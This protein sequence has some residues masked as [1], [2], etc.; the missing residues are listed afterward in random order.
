SASMVWGES[1]TPFLLLAAFLVTAS[2]YM[3]NRFSDFQEDSINNP[4]RI[5]FLRAGKKAIAMIYA[6]FFTVAAAILWFKGIAPFFTSLIFPLMVAAYSLRL[7]QKSKARGLKQLPF[8]KNAFTALGWSMLVF[9]A[10]SYY[11]LGWLAPPVISF[12]LLV[13]LWRFVNVA[14]ADFKDV[15][16]DSIAGVATLPVVLGVRKTR[17][18]LQTVN[19]AAVAVTTW[20]VWSAVLPPMAYGLAFIGVYVAYYVEESSRLVGDERVSEWSSLVLDSECVWW[21]VLVSVFA[22]LAS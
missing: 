7:K 21:A 8:V 5:T 18:V 10:A 11:G 20:L 2:S 22:R 13:L 14:A 12:F 4:A 9:L 6:V 16:G 1:P 17:I 3:I 15:R 19:L